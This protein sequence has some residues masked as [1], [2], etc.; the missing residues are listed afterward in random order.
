ME[1]KKDKERLRRAKQKKYQAHHAHICCEE[2]VQGSG[3]EEVQQGCIT[4]Q[5]SNLFTGGWTIARPGDGN[6]RLRRMKK[7]E[8]EAEREY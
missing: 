4:K 7:E 6:Q 1:E 8:T 5:D 3:K 2:C